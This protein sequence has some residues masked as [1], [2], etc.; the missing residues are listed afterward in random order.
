MRM[1]SAL[2][3]ALMLLAAASIS[4]AEAKKP[5][6]GL[7]SMGPMKFAASGTD[8]VNTLEPLNARAGIFGGIV[9]LATW[10][11]LQQS[12]SSGIAENNTIDKA[13]E[14]VRA[15]NRKNP[16]KPLAVK[17]R[18][19]AG[20]QAPDWAKNIGGPP[21]SVYHNQ[22]RTLGRFWSPPYRKAWAHFQEMLA[23]KYDK[24]PLIHE[25]AGTSCMTFTA[26]PFYLADE[27]TVSK[28]L[29]AAG[30]KPFQFKQCLMNMVSDYAPWKT[31]NLEV[32]LNPVYMP[33]GNPKGDPGFTEQFMRECRKAIGK[34]CIFDN[35]DF[36]TKPPT[37]IVPIFESMKKIGPPIEF[38][39]Y[40]ETPPDF[41]GTIQK[42]ASMGAGSIELWQDYKG[43]QLQPDEKLRKW[44][45][46][47]E[48]N[49]KE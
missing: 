37:T 48:K 26:E 32:P 29:N 44:A 13:L 43:F 47:I 38:Q 11:E 19:W 39:T 36:D 15:Y 6:R 1:H 27:A 16:Q 9:I 5:I 28:P 24:E 35:H 10:R 21:I 3:T 34:R 46:M 31:T 33:L 40:H 42:A 12:A 49:A 18:V 8:P 20:F 25:V 14:E 30:F 2:F 4:A 45:A 22:A 41:D 23:A 7:V 17:L